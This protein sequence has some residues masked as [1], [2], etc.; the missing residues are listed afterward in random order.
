MLLGCSAEKLKKTLMSRY[1]V[2]ATDLDNGNYI[3][4]TVYCV[5]PYVKVMTKNAVLEWY[6]QYWK[7]IG[8]ANSIYNRVRLY[9]QPG[10][11][12]RVL[13]TIETYNKKLLE[14]KVHNYLRNYHDKT[15]LR[16]ELFTF[17]SSQTFDLLDQMVDDLGLLE[18]DSIISITK[19]D[20]FGILGTKEHEVAK[21]KSLHF[22]NLFH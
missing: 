6:E 9:N 7:K 8:Q 4:D 12:C 1:S 15:A 16:T 14:K 22:Q 20:E 5:V 13:W 19:Y 2:S 3:P 10:I 18:S 21:E 11:D 17:D